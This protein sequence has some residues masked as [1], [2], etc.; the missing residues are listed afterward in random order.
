MPGRINVKKKRTPPDSPHKKPETPKKE[1]IFLYMM[2]FAEF[3]LAS[4]FRVDNL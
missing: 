2:L 1:N 4:I 3:L